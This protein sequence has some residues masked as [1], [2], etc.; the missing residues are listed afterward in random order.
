MKIFTFDTT[1]RDGTQAEFVSFSAEDK[2]LIAA[3]LDELGIDYIEGGWP[4]SNPKD[5]EFFERAKS[6][7][8]KHA[9]LTAFGATRFAKNPVQDDDNIA[10][11]LAA[12]TP[13]VSIFG[14]T[15]DFH[16]RRALGITEEENLRLISESV[17]YLKAHG[18]EVVYDAEHFFDGYIANPTFALRTLEAAKS[19]GAD[20]LCLCD[21][22]G[23]TLPPR[24]VEIV[25]QVRARFEGVLG[26]HCHND[27][28]VAVA[29]TIL[30]V[31]GGVTHV[32]G[33]INGYGER[34]GNANL[35]SILPNLELK[36]G[37]T[38][39]GPENL[40]N[41]T[42]VARFVAE[43]ANLPLRRDQAFVGNSAFAHKGGVHVSAVMKDSATYEHV[44]PELVGNRQRVLL[45]DLSGRGNIAF[46]LNQLGLKDSLTDA[47]RHEL[48]QRIKH[49]EHQGYD[50]E[51][52]EGTFELLVRETAQPEFHPFD[53]V[54][55][56]VSTK[57]QNNLG[58]KVG[59][60]DK[61][62]TTASVTLR[63]G[64]NVHSSTATGDGPVHALDICL[65]QCLASLY[66]AITGVHLT[67][68]KVR[69]LGKGGTESKVRVLVEWSDHRRTWATVGVSTNVIDASWRALVDALRLEL[70]R[71]R[72]TDK[73]F[74]DNNRDFSWAV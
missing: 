68:Y 61:T 1:L 17:S 26:I 54:S 20:V 13:I 9:K 34:C 27:C 47:A 42:Q 21:T 24:L 59:A 32:Q 6:L 15:W 38:T 19:S 36:L 44:Q 56:Q 5:K 48:L 39:I 71:L 41:L 22:N 3:K 67:D 33:C 50:F 14:K 35:C 37:H 30:A 66:P 8:L 43:L 49:M 53:V 60:A 7:N 62:L 16:V 72:E 10:Q 2:L 55:Y 31:E 29:N 11:L 57:L 52:A 28:D 23:G 40:K 65:R 73:R 64:E 18:R 4:G 58:K 25:A 69:V 74:G 46:K 63:V 51:T 70:M 12:G 45:S